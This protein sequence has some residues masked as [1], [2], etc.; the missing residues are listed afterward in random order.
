MNSLCTSKAKWIWVTWCNWNEQRTEIDVSTFYWK[1]GIPAVPCQVREP[2][3]NHNV[4][5]NGLTRAWVIRCSFSPFKCHSVMGIGPSPSVLD[6]Y[7]PGYQEHQHIVLIYQW[8]TCI[9][10]YIYIYILLNKWRTFWHDPKKASSVNKTWA[11]DICCATNST[12][13]TIAEYSQNNYF[14]YDKPDADE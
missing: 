8:F 5:W 9:Y 12:D 14:T 2:V 4:C 6:L 1:R 13:T 10:M 11:F 7:S 3:L